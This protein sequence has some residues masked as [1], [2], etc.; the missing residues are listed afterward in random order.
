MSAF[1]HRRVSVSRRQAERVVGGV[2]YDHEWGR[3]VVIF[4]GILILIFLATLANVSAKTPKRARKIQFDR[5]PNASVDPDAGMGITVRAAAPEESKERPERRQR[6]PKA[7]ISPIGYLKYQK[8]YRV[9]MNHNGEYPTPCW[10]CQTPGH[11]VI[12]ET[13]D[14]AGRLI[15]C[16]IRCFLKHADAGELAR[17]VEGSADFQRVHECLCALDK[18]RTEFP[19]PARRP[20]GEVSLQQEIQMPFLGYSEIE[21]VISKINHRAWTEYDLAKIEGRPEPTK[22]LTVAGTKRGRTKSPKGEQQPADNGNRSGP[23]NQSPTS[24]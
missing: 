3:A 22:E 5:S 19:D 16:C 8:P 11:S 2:G 14:S 23:D 4:V 21:R 9:R 17:A 1:S 24:T 13:T 20:Y 12:T 10:I 15:R 18:L 6:R 7:P